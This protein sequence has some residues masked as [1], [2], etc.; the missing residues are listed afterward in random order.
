[1]ISSIITPKMKT[2]DFIEKILS[3]TYSG[4]TWP[5]FRNQ[6]INRSNQSFYK[7]IIRIQ[8]IRCIEKIDNPKRVFMSKV[9]STNISFLVSMDEK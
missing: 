4:A 7:F 8:I 5:L 1:M 9:L 2:S 6:I 3:I